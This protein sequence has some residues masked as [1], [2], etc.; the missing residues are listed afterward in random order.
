MKGSH[1]SSRY[2]GEVPR[3]GG[4]GVMTGNTMFETVLRRL[5]LERKRSAVA[6]LIALHAAG[7]PQWTPRNYAALAAGG[8]CRQCRRLSLACA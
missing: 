7:R 3:S 1:P 4:G 5:G 2:A 8:L 6:P